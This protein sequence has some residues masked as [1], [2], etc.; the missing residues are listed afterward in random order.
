MVEC[1]YV[2]ICKYMCFACLYIYIYISLLLLHYIQYPVVT[3]VLLRCLPQIL[4]SWNVWS[5]P[6]ICGPKAHQNLQSLRLKVNPCRSPSR[7]GRLPS[8]RNQWPAQG[9]SHG[10][11]HNSKWW[12]MTNLLRRYYLRQPSLY[13]VTY[14]VWLWASCWINNHFCPLC[15]W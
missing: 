15:H 8:R 7:R 5:W 4:Q 3:Y 1:L 2:Y 12:I 14:P 13:R 10:H 11:G 9:R 6:P